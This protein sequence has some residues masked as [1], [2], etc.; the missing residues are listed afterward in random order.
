MS[1]REKT[2][3][4]IGLG[5][6]GGS[7]V[8]AVKDA[9]LPWQ[10]IGVARREETRR[11]ALE[12]GA[13]D[14]AQASALEAVAEADVVV[15]ALP[16]LTV[17]SLLAELA[18]VLRPGTIVTD[19]GSTKA[20]L[21]RQADDLLPDGVSFV[22]GHPIAGTE[23]S[24]FSASFPDLFRGARCILTPGRT[25]TP[26]AIDTVRG[27]WE[28]VG[29]LVESMDPRVHDRI[30]AVISHLPHVVAYALVNSAAAFD[31]ELPGLL[32]Y[33]GGGF[34][35]FTRIAASHSVMWRDICLDNR[36]ALLEALDGF[37]AET[38]RMRDLI[39]TDDAP[40]LEEGFD[41]ARAVRRSLQ[42][43]RGGETD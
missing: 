4:V 32:G 13:V 26:E 41:S 8:R 24:G 23:D 39:A 16:V 21:T 29:S 38:S 34:R 43:P 18:P 40:G 20:S 30:L 17:P 9:G 5:L 27:L 12:A 15:F 7:L 28:G 37:I 33:T 42:G 25:S 10:V 11:E 31:R 35:D 3:A 36:D 22:G 2:L 6:I 19:V 14:V 1:D